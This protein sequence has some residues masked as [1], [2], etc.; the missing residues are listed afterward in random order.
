MLLKNGQF[1]ANNTTRL[2]GEMLGIKKK[3]HILCH[4][5]TSQL[6]GIL[7][8]CVFGKIVKRCLIDLILQIELIWI[9][10]I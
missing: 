1:S 5:M 8:S 7:Q 4:I 6:F 3:S 9:L 2:I 10:V